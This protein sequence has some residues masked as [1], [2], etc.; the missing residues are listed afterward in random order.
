MEEEKDRQKHNIKSKKDLNL[1]FKK[2][3]H[4]PGKLFKAPLTLNSVL[5]PGK[6]ADKGKP[7]NR[8]RQGEKKL[9]KKGKLG[10]LKLIRSNSQHPNTIPT[11]S[12]AKYDAK[13]S[14]PA[15]Y[16]LFEYKNNKQILSSIQES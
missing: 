2:A 16:I 8:V 6:V 14:Y 9:P 13:I 1:Q 3:N 15:S 12:W 11:K 5:N 10:C 7:Y 4:V